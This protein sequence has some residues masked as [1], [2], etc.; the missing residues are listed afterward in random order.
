M[1][2][3]EIVG[4][5]AGHAALSLAPQRPGCGGRVGSGREN[6]FQKVFGSAVSRA[7]VWEA[8]SQVRENEA[9]EGWETGDG[10]D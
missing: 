10:A 1:T 5:W 2:Q 7:S 4:L 8:E 6:S 3:V 9:R